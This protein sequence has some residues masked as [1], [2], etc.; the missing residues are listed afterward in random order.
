MKT[1]RKRAFPLIASSLFLFATACSGGKKQATETE[2]LPSSAV[3]NQPVIIETNRLNP[4]VRYQEERSV[5]PANPPVVLDF[6]QK[7]VEQ[8]LS[9]NDYF[10]KA[11]CVTLKHPLPA[12]QGGFL[13]D[14][15]IRIRYDGGM[16][17]S[18][19]SQTDIQVK[20]PYILTKDL[21]GTLLYDMNGT[22][23]DSTGLTP[24]KNI[25][26]NAAK[27]EIEYQTKNRTAL[28]QGLALL[29]GDKCLYLQH[30][31][32]A[33]YF[34]MCWKSMPDG[35]ILQ[36]IRFIERPHTTYLQDLD[37]TA[38]FSQN[39][40]FRAAEVLTTFDRNTYDTLCVFHN[41][42]RPTVQPKGPFPFPEH[43]WLY[44]N[45]GK[46]Y[47][48]QAFNDTVFHVASANKLVPV[49]LLELGEKGADINTTLKGDLSQSLVA[50]QWL[51]TDK[52]ILFTYTRNYD[53][54]N[55]RRNNTVTYHYALYDKAKKQLFRLPGEG[56]YPDEYILPA[57]LTGGIP[58]LLQ[59]IKFQDHKLVTTYTK[60][61]LEALQKL[62]GFK[63]LP[64]G[65]QDRVRQLSESLGDTEMIVMMLE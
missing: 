12:D 16:S 49:Y 7:L 48:R 63:Q 50:A 42:N 32:V 25:K 53:C 57:D 54:L 26:Y 36:E 60:S 55:T 8:P 1:Q 5:D 39:G 44:R 13:Y 37:E 23:V 40:S 11:T 52:F 30:D 34:K 14:F 28:T 51:D 62:K 10:T 21:F 22:L 9:L 4:G 45:N 35:K 3:A 46:L 61:K 65:Q 47:Y 56:I 38:L 6:T 17:M 31:T 2:N 29:E 27:R 43:T 58:V 19:G 64:V 33:D 41:Y 24:I 20:T 15:S 18:T 59:D